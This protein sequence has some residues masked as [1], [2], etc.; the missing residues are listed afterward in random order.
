MKYYGTHPLEGGTLVAS[1]DVTS[2]TSS[3]SLTGIF[4]PEVM[5]FIH[6]MDYRPKNNQRT[7]VYIQSGRRDIKARRSNM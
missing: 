7:L 1:S 6:A 5:Y 2:N 3:V 4:D